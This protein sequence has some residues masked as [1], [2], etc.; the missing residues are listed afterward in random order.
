[1]KSPAMVEALERLSMIQFGRSRAQCFAD[2][3]C[4][5]CGGAAKQFRNDTSK[6]E[7][8]L[9]AMCQRCQDETFESTPEEQQE[10]S[11]FVGDVTLVRGGQGRSDDDVAADGCAVG[12]I[13][14]ACALGWAVLALL[15]WAVF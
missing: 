7:Y 15:W 13:L 5:A 3:T 9:S 10:F 4:I 14:L 8:S 2:L 1:M 6:V 11:E 12:C